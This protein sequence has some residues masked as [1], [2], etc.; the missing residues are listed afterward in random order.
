[1][2]GTTLNALIQK[3]RLELKIA[4]SPALGKNT[5]GSHAY[6]LR[7]AQERLYSEHDWPFK[8]IHRD[9]TLA[10]GQRY[11]A[12]PVDLDLEG[13][14]KVE[15]LYSG[16]WYE[17][18][19]GIRTEDYNIFN[20]EA[21][22][23]SDPALKWDIFNDPDGGD[24][25]EVFPLPASN[26]STI[27]FTGTKKLS[28]LVADDDTAD[29][30]DTLLVLTA[31]VDFAGPKDVQRIQGKAERYYFS[32]RRNLSD[33]ATFVSGGGVD[34]NDRVGRRPPQIVITPARTG[35]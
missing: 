21:D 7:S 8:N 31:A 1:M 29:M 5:R 17:L 4:E 25:I 6:A 13:I 30:D 24:M 26:A 14:R 15:L 33:G 10:A 18:K 34:P 3:L 9:V 22:A 19:R 12:P 35:G 28:A 27:R 11:Y 32:L 20:S 23:R 2:R 16:I